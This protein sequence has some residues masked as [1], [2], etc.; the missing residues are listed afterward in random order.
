MNVDASYVTISGSLPNEK[1]QEDYFPIEKPKAGAAKDQLNGALTYYLVQ[2]LRRNPDA[3]YREIMNQVQTTVVNLKR[4]QTPQAEGAIDRIVFGSGSSRQKTPIFVKS[5]ET[6]KRMFDGKQTEVNEIQM[7]VGNIAGAQNGGVVAVY[8]PKARELEGDKDKIATGSIT[9]ANAFSSKAD[10]VLTDKTIKTVPLDAKVILVTPNFSDKKRKVALDFPGEARAAQSGAMTRLADILKNNE[11]LETV[12]V[13]NLLPKLNAKQEG[14]V[15]TPNWDVAV[16]RGTYKDFTFGNEQPEVKDAKIPADAEEIY[17]LANRSGMPL[18]NFWV[19]ATDENAA[20]SIRDALESHV[21]VENLRLLANTASKLTEQ[22]QFELVRLSGYNVTDS[23][24]TPPKCAVTPDEQNKSLQFKSGDLFYVKMT[25]ASERNLYVYLYSITTTGKIN[26]LYPTQN[27]KET[28]KPNL[29]FTS[30][31]A[32]GCY[33][34]FQVGKPEDMPLGK[35]T[36]KLIA[37]TEPF[38]AELLTSPAVAKTATRDGSALS[39]LLS[40]TATNQRSGPIEI[41]V[42]DWVTKDINIEIVR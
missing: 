3:T 39:K 41:S 10:V 34:I 9:F 31:A 36:L 26:L 8:N 12:Q 13:K 29:P 37:T 6:V 16:V 27:A 18:Y 28:L 33:G 23:N 32:S 5:S 19:R 21:R 2:N 15:I 4:G 25:N 1:S 42:S 20:K 35:E 40:Q 38:P 11:L 14:N 17:F 7:D 22:I 30:V 24:A